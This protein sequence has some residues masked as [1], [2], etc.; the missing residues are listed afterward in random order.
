MC[1][2][3]IPSISE[4]HVSLL[5]NTSDDPVIEVIMAKESKMNDKRRLIDKPVCNIPTSFHFS[6]YCLIKSLR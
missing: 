3:S 5:G 4:E 2:T 6:R 1:I